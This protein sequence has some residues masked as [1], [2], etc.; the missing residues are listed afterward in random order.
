MSLFHF[1]TLIFLIKLTL[2]VSLTDNTLA[3]RCL[4][5]SCVY[6]HGELKCPNQGVVYFVFLGTI[7]FFSLFCWVILVKLKF[8]FT[9]VSFPIN[10]MP[11][12]IGVYILYSFTLIVYP[13]YTIQSIT[14]IVPLSL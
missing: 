6:G 7:P 3:L 10:F 11:I 1:P 9:I 8:S 4:L 12:S 14:F 13:S 2:P 5:S